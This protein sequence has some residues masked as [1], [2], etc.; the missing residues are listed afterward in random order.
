MS[1]A[2]RCSWFLYHWIRPWQKLGSTFIPHTVNA[3]SW[4]CLCPVLISAA[5]PTG[6]TGLSTLAERTCPSDCVIHGKSVSSDQ[7]CIFA[8]HELWSYPSWANADDSLKAGSPGEIWARMKRSLSGA[9][10]LSLLLEDYE[11][12]L[13]LSHSQHSQQQLGAGSTCT[14][15]VGEDIRA[16]TIRHVKVTKL[17]I[18]QRAWIT[19]PTSSQKTDLWCSRIVLDNGH[20]K[21]TL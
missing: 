14:W 5:I 1:R 4:W 20:A 12:D 16:K 10:N 13:I 3:I 18:D 9:S 17:E 19:W 6:S 8:C 2:L 21:F 7:I 11:V 15:S